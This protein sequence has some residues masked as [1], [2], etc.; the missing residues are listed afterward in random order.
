ME[1]KVSE[2]NQSNQLDDEPTTETENKKDIQNTSARRA[3]RFKKSRDSWKHK[4]KKKRD[5]IKALE[6]KT[7]D[8][9]V[10]R[11]TWKERAKQA[12]T[13]LKEVKAKLAELGAEEA[14]QKKGP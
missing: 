7:R 4:T 5:V 14:G 3:R 13:K 8:L 10:S 12:E 1:K 6:V 11:E 2:L 9:S